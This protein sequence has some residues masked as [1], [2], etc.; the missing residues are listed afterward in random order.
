MAIAWTYRHDYEAVNFPML[1]VRDASGAKVARWSLIC[2]VAVVFVSALPSVLA[3]TSSAY[4]VATLV[5]GAWFI[6]RSISFLR[7]TPRE[8]AA[9]RLFFASIIWLPL[10]LAILVADRW[11]GA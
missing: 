3:L 11:L 5:L 1:S 9:R 8:A 2:T 6:A 4:F 7:K 10:Q